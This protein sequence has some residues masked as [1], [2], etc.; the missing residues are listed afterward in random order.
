MEVV[1]IVAVSKYNNGIG[2]DNRLLWHLPADMKFFK[3]TTTGYPVITG[4][5]NYESIPEKF[6]PLPNRENI[7]LTRQNT[8]YADAEVCNSIE[9]ALELARNHKKE[10]AF[11]I[12]GGEIYNQ[13]LNKNLVDKILITWVDA[14]FDADVFFPKLNSNWKISK[15]EAHTPDE[16]NKY[17]YNFT[18]YS[19]K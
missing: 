4:R 5:K 9:K 10:K 8:K 15:E 2:K 19:K 12:G 6:R 3:S 7:I 13:F 1:L 14:P 16:K 11:V 17:A 18:E